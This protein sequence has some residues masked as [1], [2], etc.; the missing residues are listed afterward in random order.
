MAKFKKFALL[1]TAIFACAT[2]AFASGCDLFVPVDSGS[3]SE[4]IESSE[5][6]SFE[7]SSESSSSEESSESSSSEESSSD[8]STPEV[9]TY[10]IKFVDENGTVLQEVEVEKGEMPVYNGDTPTKAEDAQ[11]TYT[12]AGWDPTILE[13]TDEATYTAT[14]LTTTKKYVIKFVNEDGT[15]LQ[16]SE[17]EYGAMP[18]YNGADPIK[19]GDV[20]Y[21]YTFEGW[22]EVKAVTGEATYTATYKEVTNKYVVKFVNED[23]TVLQSSELEYGAM[24]IYEGTPTMKPNA[25]YSYV[26]IGWDKTIA[27]VTGDVTYTAKYDCKILPEDAKDNFVDLEDCK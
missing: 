15:V 3:S 21:S 17:V 4:V 27:E 2:V 7:E 9:E 25:P 16:S 11:F 22:G 23:G 19:T 18:I 1:C 24:P 12:F 26:F 6:G 13:V 5:T 10:T 14:Y 20:Q 8:S